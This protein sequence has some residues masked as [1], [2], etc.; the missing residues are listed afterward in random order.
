MRVPI[1]IN[2][3]YEC[4]TSFDRH[5]PWTKGLCLLPY[6]ACGK[7]IRARVSPTAS[8]API[9]AVLSMLTAGSAAMTS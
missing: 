9:A 7:T 8:D 4:E 3:K 1:E 5:R 2:K 6:G